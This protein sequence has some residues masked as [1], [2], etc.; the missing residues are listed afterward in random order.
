VD[1]P[2][3]GRI[4]RAVRLR[5]GW[6]QRDVALKANLSQ[7]E[8]SD[9]E[10]GHF[11]RVSLPHAR[12]VARVT[13]ISLTLSARWRGPEL[14]RLLD[15]GHASIVETVVGEL[16]REG[17]EVL[18][19]WSFSH[20]GER[21]SVDV[22]AWHSGRRALVIIEVKT[23]IVDLG[24]ML[25]TLDRK[26]RLDTELLRSERGW[27][28]D[29]IGRVLV[30]L[31]TSANRDRI[32]QNSSVFEA[33]MPARTRDVRRWLVNP[34]GSVAGLWFVR[35]TAV[36]GGVNHR[37]RVRVNSRGWQSATRAQVP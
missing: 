30:L 27:R 18:V 15:A 25:S 8:V 22:A 36:G 37:R 10:C 24:D 12:R 13:G 28:A 14:D 34:V 4:F 7:Q 2:T 1:D 33:V 31:S 26:V 19:E 32:A 21:G 3:V 29:A 20:F 17:W 5:L 11:E 9:V 16:R 6:R 23:Q 35:P